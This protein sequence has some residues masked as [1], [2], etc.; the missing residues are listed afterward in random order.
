MQKKKI[1]SVRIGLLTIF[2]FSMAIFQGLSLNGVNDGNGGSVVTQ[3]VAGPRSSAEYLDPNQL[4][5]PSQTT[6]PLEPFTFTMGDF[7]VMGEINYDDG[8]YT[9]I[10]ST[11]QSVSAGN[12]EIDPT[13][14][15]SYNWTIVG[16]FLYDDI[17]MYNDEDSI[18]A[19]TIGDYFEVEL[20]DNADLGP[21]EICTQ[22]NVAVVGRVTGIPNR[23]AY[24]EVGFN[25]VGSP[26]TVDYPLFLDD[27]WTTGSA[28]FYGL[29]LN[30]TEVNDLSL[31]CSWLSG[32]ASNVYVDEVVV[33]IYKAAITYE[34]D[35]T[36]DFLV[37]ENNFYEHDDIWYDYSTNET[38]ECY[39]YV[40]N[41][42][43][44]SWTQTEFS[45]GTSWITA[46]HNVHQDEANGSNVTIRFQAVSYIPFSL[47]LDMLY[48]WYTKYHPPAA[49]DFT[50]TTGYDSPE[51]DGNYT[52]NWNNGSYT[53]LWYV[54]ESND[55]G[56]GWTIIAVAYTNSLFVMNR[57]VGVHMY[58]VTADNDHPGVTTSDSQLSL[59]VFGPPGAFDFETTAV[60]NYE[61]P[62]T[63]GSFTLKWIDADTEDNYSI[64]CNGELVATGIPENQTSYAVENNLDGTYIYI[65]EAIN[66]YGTTNS[67]SNVT[68]AV[69]IFVS[70]SGLSPEQIT[71]IAVIGAGAGVVVVVVA[72]KVAAK[73]KKQER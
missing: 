14:D 45:N 52:L 16:S 40:Q 55:S 53:D 21:N 13:A 12:V 68:I 10:A 5:C 19:S 20:G 11:Y 15:V 57:A 24:L 59:E 43:D 6:G 30:D 4:Y 73:R 65:I 70:S 63:D 50:P 49:F 61:N 27:F 22:I 31:T 34:I 18:Y 48:V 41:Y 26:S 36:V 9:E 64:Y 38:V 67:T 62:D 47:Y 51:L 54:Y 37:D 7:D 8:N 39:I 42:T 56:F 28:N 71:L 72:T 2:L 1:N 46:N 35:F 25:G 29:A 60:L 23:H 3:D 66:E 33:T 17:N 58:V 44:Y 32:D 69:E